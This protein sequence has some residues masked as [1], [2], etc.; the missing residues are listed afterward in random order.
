MQFKSRPKSF[1]VIGIIVA[2]ASSGKEGV[3]AKANK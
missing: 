2:I 1:P 3:P